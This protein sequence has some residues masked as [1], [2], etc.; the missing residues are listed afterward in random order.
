MTHEDANRISEILRKA[1]VA[2]WITHEEGLRLDKEVKA[3]W[4]KG[5]KKVKSPELGT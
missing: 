1:Y 3:T 4:N 2:G 5:R